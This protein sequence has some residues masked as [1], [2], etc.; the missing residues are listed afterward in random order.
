MYSYE[1]PHLLPL[2]CTLHAFFLHSFFLH[3]LDIGLGQVQQPLLIQRQ[4]TTPGKQWYHMRCVCIYL[5]IY[6]YVCVYIHI[7][8]YLHVC[9][10]VCAYIIY[11]YNCVCACIYRIYYIQYSIVICQWFLVH[12]SESWRSRRCLYRAN[13][14][15]EIRVPRVLPGWWGFPLKMHKYY[16]N[17]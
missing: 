3:S 9:V 16:T 2:L 14:D 15:S 1:L 6:I 12:V 13:R 10:C 17:S 7:Y 8:I 11:M 4:W 5:Y